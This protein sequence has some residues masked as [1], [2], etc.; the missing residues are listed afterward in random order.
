MVRAGCLPKVCVAVGLLSVCAEPVVLRGQS[1][2]APADESAPQG[3][4]A[5][6]APSASPGTATAPAAAA[7]RAEPPGAIYREAMHPLDV[8]RSSVDN[9]SDAEVGAL[10]AGMHRAREACAQIKPGDVAGDDLYD[11]A[12]LCSF[13][14]DWNDAN[15]AALA[16]VASR[17]ETHRAEAYALS[18]YALVHLNAIDLAVQT[19]EEMLR[20]L[21]YDA[22]VAYSLRDL[23][24]YLEQAG[25]AAAL[26][27]ARDEH[28]A[29]V[30]AIKAGGPLKAAHGEGA[31]GVGS[32]FESGMELAFFEQYAGNGDAAA[33]VQAELERA[34]PLVT[35]LPA[36]DRRRIDAV[37]TQ[38]GLLGKALPAIDA[39]KAYQSRTAKA[40]IGKNYGAATVLVVFPDWC[41]Q[42]RKMMTTMTQFA[43]VN[44]KTPIHAYGLM[45]AEDA[46][47][48]GQT[49]GQAG[50][51]AGGQAHAEDFK[52][53]QGTSTLLVDPKT[54][55]TLG[56][57][58]F[59]MGVVVDG[60]GTVRFVGLLPQDAFNGDGYVEKVI[61]RMVATE[62]AKKA[63]GR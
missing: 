29:M 11:L 7:P 14:Q 17:E 36:E 52:E 30:Q 37:N 21:P 10:A 34:L 51:R 2:A 4:S 63:A 22:E 5:A 42:C 39:K 35:T 49:A 61:L 33:A 56:A 26:T 41:V 23:K 6:P 16:Y 58:D 62:T 40:Q 15:T 24:V 44:G 50:G 9:W 54:A 46:D 55:V 8:V 25:N 59:P 48:A 32:L 60:A 13:G 19:A 1:T 45:F 18:V 20:K 31:F 57:T 43:M 28:A 53:L 47:S 27:L 12:R 38:F 3:G